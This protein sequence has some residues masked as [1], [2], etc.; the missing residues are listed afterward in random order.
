MPKVS[1]LL[2]VYKPKKEYL[3]ECLDS[4]LNQ[5][6]KD[7][8]LIILDDC[9]ED[10]SSEDIIKN[11]K[12]DRI[13]YFRNNKNLGISGTRN[14]LIDISSGEYLAIMDHDDISLPERFKLEVDYLD[15]NP[16]IGVVSG[17]CKFI[18]ANY[19]TNYPENDRDI[20]LSL[21]QN[22]FIVHPASM[23]RKSMLVENNIRYEEEFSPAEDYALWCRLIK[24]TKFHNLSNILLNYRDHSNNVSHKNRNAVDNATLAVRAFVQ[25]N[26]PDLY[27]EFI[28]KSEVVMKIK[29]FGIIPFLWT[30][31]GLHTTKYLLFNMFTLFK[32]KKIINYDKLQ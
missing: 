31:K 28:F 8:E 1:V 5:S 27:R 14:K 7:F 13:K 9:P 15:N 3:V 24:I 16:D 29:L 11:Y 18:F 23:I 30:Y 12:D 25:T 32:I 21:M 2:P 17:N 19:N 10:K 20:R 6:F 4:I 26:N 22:C